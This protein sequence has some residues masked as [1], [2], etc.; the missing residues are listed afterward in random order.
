MGEK[1]P[2]NE[3]LAT[4]IAVIDGHSRRT[5]GAWRPRGA[6]QSLWRDRSFWLVKVTA[7]HQYRLGQQ[8]RAEILLRSSQIRKLNAFDDVKNQDCIADLCACQLGLPVSYPGPVVVL[9]LRSLRS[10]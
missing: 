9:L 1:P 7:N 10:G 4:Y 3:A 8:T 6:R 5:W 2:E